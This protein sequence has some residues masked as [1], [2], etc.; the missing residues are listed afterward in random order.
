MHIPSEVVE[1]IGI[2]GK[3]DD[4]IRRYF[5][6]IPVADCAPNDSI[7]RH[8]W[9]ADCS[10]VNSGGQ[11]VASHL[12]SCVPP[13]AFPGSR[14]EGRPVQDSLQHSYPL[15][16]F[17]AVTH[18]SPASIRLTLGF[19]VRSVPVAYRNRKKFFAP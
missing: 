19:V 9:V 12:H 5:P 15:E 3:S 2:N 13:D 10:D 1:L 7:R 17:A 11:G 18:R 4:K 16:P 6:S 8:G 14:S